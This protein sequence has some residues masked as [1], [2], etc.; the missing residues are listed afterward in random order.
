MR[1]VQT[2]GFVL[3]GAGGIGVAPQVELFQAEVHAGQQAV[4]VAG[5]I[6]IE[7]IPWCKGE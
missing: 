7:D 2:A 3:V 1:A 4:A 5:Q 6:G